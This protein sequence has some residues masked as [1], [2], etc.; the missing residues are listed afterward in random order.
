MTTLGGLSLARVTVTTPKR[1]MDVAL[2]DNMAV[3]ELLPHLLRHAGDGLA[4]DGERHGGWVLRRA[5]G[6][7]LEPTRS[8]AEIGGAHV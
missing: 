6:T 2:P 4:D 7:L 8:L 1:R 5:T 3:G